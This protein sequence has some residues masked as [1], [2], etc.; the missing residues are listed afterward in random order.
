MLVLKHALAR[1]RG[2][3]LFT[4]IGVLI[5]D[6]TW[7]LASVAG[8]TALLVSSQIAFDVVRY[9]GA[10]YLIY[11]GIRL[12]LTRQTPIASEDPEPGRR[13]QPTRHG[14]L[15]AFREGLI[16]DLSNPKTI[17]IFTSIIPQFLNSNASPLDALILGITFAVIGFLNLTAYALAFGTAAGLLRD[18]RITRSIL[19]IGGALLTAFGIGLAAE[20]P[21]S[22]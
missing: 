9:L 21:A 4:A 20:R 18:A 15:R 19:R 14:A 2:P 22:T 16:G 13:P 11:L 1:G 17:I 12:I 5:A 10:A 8:L 6:L 3:A 7:A